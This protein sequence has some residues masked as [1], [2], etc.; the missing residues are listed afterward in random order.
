MPSSSFLPSS[1]NS[2]ESLPCFLSSSHLLSK[3]NLRIQPSEAKPISIRADP[4]PLQLVLLVAKATMRQLSSES[5]EKAKI[6][7]ESEVE[8]WLT[9]EGDESSDEPVEAEELERWW[10]HERPAEERCSF[11]RDL[12]GFGEFTSVRV[13]SLASCLFRLLSPRVAGVEVELCGVV[14]LKPSF[15]WWSLSSDSWSWILPSSFFFPP[16]S[17]LEWYDLPSWL[18]FLLNEWIW[19]MRA[20]EVETRRVAP[21]RSLAMKRAVVE[22]KVDFSFWE[23]RIVK[24]GR[25]IG[26]EVEVKGGIE[27]GVR[28]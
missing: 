13:E 8:E 27:E 7:A 15:D 9:V 16:S 18:V 19:A 4:L 20:K 28:L 6:D 21:G 12:F 24:G 10:S 2:L 14:I 22:G 25:Q 26:W 17:K 23:R 11:F 5:K 3:T 1:S